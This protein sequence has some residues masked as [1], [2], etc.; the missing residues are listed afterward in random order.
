MYHKHQQ[1]EESWSKK[2][3]AREDKMN[4]DRGTR[5]WVWKRM[6]DRFRDNSN[7]EVVES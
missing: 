3:L 2:F 5:R 4:F 6:L 7:V 1:W